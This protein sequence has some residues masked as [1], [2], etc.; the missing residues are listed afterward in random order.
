MATHLRTATELTVRATSEGCEQTWSFAMPPAEPIRLW[1]DG[2]LR[3]YD[4]ASDTW[5]EVVAPPTGEGT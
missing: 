1:L 5:T 3:Q 2:A 4:P